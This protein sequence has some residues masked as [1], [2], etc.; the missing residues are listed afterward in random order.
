MLKPDKPALHT[1]R[2]GVD[3]YRDRQE[4]RPDLELDNGMDHVQDQNVQTS[5]LAQ[6][7][8]S[9]VQARLCLREKL[10]GKNCP[11]Q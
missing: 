3:I 10:A 9:P 1:L 7:A 6:P 8:L 4:V 11:R 2:F 5:R